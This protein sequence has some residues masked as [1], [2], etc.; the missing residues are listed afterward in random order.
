M[1]VQFH[2]APASPLFGLRLISTDEIYCRDV[3]WFASGISWAGYE[4][5]GNSLLRCTVCHWDSI[6]SLLVF[7]SSQSDK[8]Q[9][10]ELSSSLCVSV[11]RMPCCGRG[12]TYWHQC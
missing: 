2:T 4:M 9:G 1:H 8:N 3:V 11:F 6:C 5:H 10:S 7:Q 12:S